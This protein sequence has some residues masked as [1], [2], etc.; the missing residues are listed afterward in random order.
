MNP[1]GWASFSKGHSA[2]ERLSSDFGQVTRVSVV[3]SATEAESRHVNRSSA[4]PGERSSLVMLEHRKLWT[5]VLT[6]GNNNS[7]TV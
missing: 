6:E 3:F 2:N 1:F 7:G 5:L 4:R